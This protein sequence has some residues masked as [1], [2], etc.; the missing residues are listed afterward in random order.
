[1]IVEIT[2]ILDEQLLA[3]DMVYLKKLKEELADK[4]KI[5]NLNIAKVEKEI[6]LKR[7]QEFQNETLLSLSEKKV[8]IRK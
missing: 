2:E 5:L 8:L 6:F 4:E 1:M 7:K 3:F